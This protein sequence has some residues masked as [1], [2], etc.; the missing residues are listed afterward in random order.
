MTSVR[1]AAW[2]C[3]AALVTVLPVDQ[4]SYQYDHKGII[5]HRHPRGELGELNNASFEAMA[6]SGVASA[7]ASKSPPASSSSRPRSLE[8][9]RDREGD[10]PLF[11]PE[12]RRLLLRY[13]PESEDWLLG[14]GGVTRPLCF[15]ASPLA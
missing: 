7:S 9:L 4:S 2:P 10:L 11:D 13:L 1:A 12:D 5:K 15:T 14:L 6:S 3:S 8:P